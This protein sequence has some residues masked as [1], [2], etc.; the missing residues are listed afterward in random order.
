MQ[1]ID[2][3]ISAENKCSFCTGSKCCTY[4]TDPISTPRSKED[5]DYLLWQVSHRN[6]ALYK[7]N[8]IWYIL[9]Q[10]ECQH[11]QSDGRCGIYAT[12]PQICRDHTNDYCEFDRDSVEDFELYF[13][14]Y[15]SL[16]DYCRN[17]FKKWDG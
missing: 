4:I 12:R 1:Q 9:I 7:D 14:D 15:P 6:V 8:G 11:L 2:I 17:R 3:E 16:L 10:G 5:F 13:P